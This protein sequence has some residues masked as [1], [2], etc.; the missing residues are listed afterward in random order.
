MRGEYMKTPILEMNHIRKCF[1]STVALDDVQ[2]N[3]YPGEIRGLIGENGSGKSTIS[4]IA[5]GMQK[6]DKGE[7]TFLGEPWAPKSMIDALQKGIGIIVQESG[8]IAGITVAENIFLAEVDQ[9]RIWG[10]KGPV[11]TA[12]MNKA[13]DA[14]LDNIGVTHVRGHMLMGSLDFQTRKLVEIAKV[15]MKNPQILIVDETTTALSQEGRE[16]LYGIMKKYRDEGRAVIFIS[17]DLDEIISVCDTLTVL[18][19]GHLIRTFHREEFDEDQ[20]RTSMIGRELKGDYYRSDFTPSHMEEVT[21]TAE[22]ITVPGVLED[23]SLQL[24]KGEIVGVGGLSHCGMHDLGKILFGAQKA[25]SGTVQAGGVRITDETVA[26]KQGIGYVAKDRDTESL[27]LSASIRDNIAIAGMERFA[28]NNF[29]VL[30][31]KEKQYVDQQIQVLEIKCA[32]RDQQVSQ[33]SGGNKQKV[34]FGKWIGRD[35]DILILDCP[36]RG[37][38]IGV[39]RAM[40]QLMVQLKQQGKSILMIS[41]EMPELMGMSDR[42]IIMKD[43]RIMKEFPRSSNLSDTEIIKYMI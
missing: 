16:T 1:S 30:S 2:L 13:A 36:T 34:V 9:F 41:E 24:R 38:D 3:V 11:S 25:A 35:S 43:G 32:D 22:H 29:L 12:A 17:H 26:M 6:C 21:L 18:R 33:L 42:L 10:G 31:S 19:D 37:V 23:V 27:T 28:V 39:K 15:V 20:I 5:A 7:M 14:V 8:T 40:Y 4:T